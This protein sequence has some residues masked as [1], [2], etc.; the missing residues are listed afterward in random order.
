MKS[1]FVPFLATSVFVIPSHAADISSVANGA[2]DA[3]AT[4]SD[5]QA[6]ARR[7]QL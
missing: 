6:P 3:A 1:K 2:W 4:W 7:Q 5:N